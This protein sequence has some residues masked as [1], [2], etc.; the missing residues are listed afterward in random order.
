MNGNRESACGPNPL[1]MLRNVVVIERGR[2]HVEIATAPL[3][4]TVRRDG[5]RLAGPIEPRVR[6]GE[7][8]DQFIQL[9]EG[10]IAGETLGDPLDLTVEDPDGARFDVHS[11][12][13]APACS[14]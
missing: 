9:T 13:A 14:R 5:R 2:L 7:I 12:T 6:D 1:P 4:V 8:H 11:P 3:T 10:V